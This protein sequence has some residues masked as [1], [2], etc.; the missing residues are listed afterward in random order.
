MAL[1]A[2]EPG[3]T[4]AS[5]GPGFRHSRS[6]TERRAAS[7]LRIWT[8]TAWACCAI[9]RRSGEV[10]DEFYSKPAIAV[11]NDLTLTRVASTSERSEFV[12]YVIYLIILE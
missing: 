11:T 6:P 5:D 7:H 12:T 3:G 1:G 10:R 4:I 2:A 9:Y 8:I